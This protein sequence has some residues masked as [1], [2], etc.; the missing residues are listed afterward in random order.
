M[1]DRGIK[2]F[3]ELEEELKTA[4]SKE[5]TGE[6]GTCTRW[7]D[8]LAQTHRCPGLAVVADGKEVQALMRAVHQIIAIGFAWRSRGPDQLVWYLVGQ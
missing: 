2:F 6:K 4:G 5:V 8:G 7:K 1:L 3:T